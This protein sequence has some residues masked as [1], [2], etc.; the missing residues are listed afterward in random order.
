[1]AI[2]R[3][4][5]SRIPVADLTAFIQAIF[6]IRSGDVP[7]LYHTPY[8]RSFNAATFFITA[9]VLSITP[10]AGFYASLHSG[11][12]VGFLHRPFDL[13]R[14]EVPRLATVLSNHKG[15]DEVLTVGYNVALA[16]RIGL[17]VPNAQVIQG[18]KGNPERRIGIVGALKQTAKASEMQSRILQ[19]F[20]GAFE[21]CFG[22]E[23]EGGTVE[24]QLSNDDDVQAVAIMN[25]FHPEEVDRVLEVSQQ[26]GLLPGNDA[27]GL[28]YLTG[29]VRQPGL[30]YALERGIKV[31]C[32]GHRICEEWGTHH[33]AECLRERF[34]NLRVDEVYEDEE[35]REH[36]RHG[37]EAK[38]QQLSKRAS[39]RGG[40]PV[41]T[42]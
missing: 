29:A 23:G 17:D 24:S 7:F 2:A 20:N 19:Q 18:Y 13:D 35:P 39:D 12:K 15:F 8:S 27:K 26:N 31:I 3:Q 41:A 25:A 33:I 28:L 5:A 11:T 42:S 10:T 30:L 6:P 32:V 34:P 40:V 1:M 21:G 22:F 38:E 9:I 37:K 4:H 14:R 36:T 16:E